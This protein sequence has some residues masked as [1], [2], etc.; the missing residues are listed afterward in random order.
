MSTGAGSVLLGSEPIRRRRAL[1]GDDLFCPLLNA[2]VEAQQAE[3]RH[4]EAINAC[5]ERSRFSGAWNFATE[6]VSPLSPRNR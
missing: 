2:S 6:P 3:I 5:N 4:G 1:A